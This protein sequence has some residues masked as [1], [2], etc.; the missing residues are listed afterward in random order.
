MQYP[1]MFAF[2]NISVRCRHLSIVGATI[3]YLQINDISRI[4]TFERARERLIRIKNDI[5]QDLS[6]SLNYRNPTGLYS[7]SK[8]TN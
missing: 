7:I 6:I 1:E 3:N 2:Y 4:K 5:E 8:K